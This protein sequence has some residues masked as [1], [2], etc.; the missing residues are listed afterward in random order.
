MHVLEAGFEV[1]NRPGVLLLHGFPEFAYSWRKLMLP[2]SFLPYSTAS[3][4]IQAG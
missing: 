3:V 4:P 2:A 1:K